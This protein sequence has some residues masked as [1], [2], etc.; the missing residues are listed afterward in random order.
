MRPMVDKQPRTVDRQEAL[1]QSVA[2]LDRGFLARQRLL[3]AGAGAV[4]SSLFDLCLCLGVGRLGLIT[5]DRVEAHNAATGIFD[6]RDLHALKV[7]ALK[8]RAEAD[9]GMAA[10]R[11]APHTLPV[12]PVGLGFFLDYDADVIAVDNVMSRVNVNRKLIRAGVVGGD[13]GIDLANGGFMHTAPGGPCFE[14]RLD[15]TAYHGWVASF[16]CAA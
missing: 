3:I 1:G 10:E 4:G 13:L 9:H 6:R 12:Q 16:P 2:Y 11:V 14:C 15:P 8:V 7:D 5:Y